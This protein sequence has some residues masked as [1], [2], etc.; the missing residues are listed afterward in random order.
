[1]TLTEMVETA[2][3][4]IDPKKQKPQDGGETVL[5][6][7]VPEPPPQQMA[8]AA[9]PQPMRT[10]AP[11]PVPPPGD[12]SLPMSDVDKAKMILAKNPMSGIVPPRPTPVQAE[13]P[14][15]TQ[16]QSELDAMKRPQPQPTLIDR[17]KGALENFGRYGAMNPAQAQ[18]LEQNR[19]QQGVDNQR[20]HQQDLV[21]R[22]KMIQD[23][24]YRQSQSA[25]QR[26][27][28][29]RQNRLADLE[30]RNVTSEIQARENPKPAA[31]HFSSS[32]Q[33]IYN[34][35]TGDV[36]R[37]APAAP[38]TMTP[39]DNMTVDGKHTPLLKDS[40]GNFYDATTRQPIKGQLGVYEKPADTEGQNQRRTDSSYDRRN[41]DLDKQAQPVSDS[42]QRVGRLMDTIDNGSPLADSVT[43]PELMVVMAG[44]QG[45]GVRITSAEINSIVGSQSKLEQLKA[46]L[47]Q[48]STN[49]NE[50]NKILEP[51]RGQIRAIVGKVHEKL[52]AKEQII[53]DA[54]QRL[55]DA[56]DVKEQRQIVADMKKQL[57]AVD[58][59]GGGFNVTDPR[60]TVHTFRT[61]A[62]ADAFKKAAG[63]K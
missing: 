21:N 28:L 36:V 56:D 38:K 41:A 11:S 58:S 34:E 15:A 47:K 4:I 30:E 49:P 57:A 44:G 23:E 62:D 7:A 12:P 5:P 8:M 9:P 27:Q 43:A 33:G 31:P 60:G 16:I 6:L 19:Q 24:D 1:M 18:V 3:Q 54:R 45:S 52:Q 46:A 29:D 61:Q 35:Q 55:I 20:Q 42:I 59:G 37:P 25:I 26:D 63:I 14:Q 40:E 53:E 48:Y 17:A 13:N 51:M 10:E 2:K 22:L 39:V 50:A 32:P